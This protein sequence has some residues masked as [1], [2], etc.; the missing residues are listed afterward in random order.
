MRSD[1]LSAF[2]QSSPSLAGRTILQIIPRLEAGGAER[3]TIDIAAALAQAGAI[4]KVA[5]EGGR[6][7]S[8]LQAKGGVWL[9]FPASSKNPVAMALNV[10]KLVRL[11][12]EE[13]VDLVHAR[14]RAPAWVAFGAATKTRTPWVTTY[15]GAYGGRSSFKTLYNS[16]M[17]RGDAVIANSEW[18]ASLIADR[19]PG[20]EPR[21]CVIHRGVDF[22]SFSPTAVDARR[23][24]KLRREWGASPEQRIILL[25]ARVTPW[26]GHRI[27]VEAMKILQQSGANDVLAVMAGDLQGRSAYAKELDQ[28]VRQAGLENHIR[29]VGH[30][31]DMPAALLAASVVA[32]PSIQPE[33]FG[34]VA[35]EAQAMGARVVVSDLGAARETVLAPPEVDDRER[36]GWRVAPND[37][38][39]LA[40]A[41]AAALNLGASAA[42]GLA[43]RGRAHVTAR[44]SLD[45]MCEQTLE[46]YRMLLDRQR[47]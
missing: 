16:V 4:A 37:P 21:V 38:E 46:V 3:T 47:S 44:F 13:K 34:R 36:T 25:A 33:A 9:P 5:C 23:V 18:T 2:A 28:S 26:K 6:L 15:H 45:R 32:V 31:S 14:S 20:A 17:A 8:E 42:D 24:Q 22:R 39:A 43:A 35:V 29:R 19:H 11:L 41:L 10:R 1:A 40:Q 12:A 7:V 30:C 27:L